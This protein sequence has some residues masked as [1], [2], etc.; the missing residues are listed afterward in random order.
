MAAIE[1]QV[2]E[3]NEHIARQTAEARVSRKRTVCVCA[4]EMVCTMLAG[5]Q[6]AGVRANGVYDVDVPH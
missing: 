2:F 3:S 4:L 1:V 5:V 6:H